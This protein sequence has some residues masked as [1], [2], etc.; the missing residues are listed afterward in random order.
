[1]SFAD[2]LA[3][4]P[5]MKTITSA[6]DGKSRFPTRC[7]T[8]QRQSPEVKTCT[9]GDTSSD[10]NIVLFG[11]SH[12]IP[13][14]NPLLRIADS[15]GWK[16][17]TVVKYGCTAFDI[18]QP[19]TRVGDRAGCASWRGEALRQIIALRPSIVFIGNSTTYLGHKDTLA[20]GFSLDE[21]QKGTRRTLAT[22]TAAGL[23]V[24]VMRDNPFFTYD[25]PTCFARS[26]RHSWYPGGSCE[27][28]QS[29]VLNPA[30]FEAEKA[31]ARDLSNVR[32]ID[33]TDRL[34]QMDIC[35]VVHGNTVIYQDN[36][37]LAGN[38]TEKMT[39]VLEGELRAIV[40]TP[41]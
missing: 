12:A 38:F 8:S 24:V 39:P 27:A 41:G 3:N 1:M 40:N 19:D 21:L 2:Q 34:C 37:H 18:T 33:I 25:I 17:V 9:F 30:V 29:V 10:I 6:I 11:D 28:D 15:N 20:M 22:L 14:F 31:G 23:R 36:H 32:F 13:W 4:E 16:L 26:A 7:V 5:G 35:R